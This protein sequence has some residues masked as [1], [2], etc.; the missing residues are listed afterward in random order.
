MI[1]APMTSRSDRIMRDIAR[2]QRDACVS[3][4]SGSC[5][6]LVLF[7]TFFFSEQGLEFVLYGAEEIGA[8]LPPS[9]QIIA[10]LWPFFASIAGGGILYACL[11]ASYWIAV[12]LRGIDRLLVTR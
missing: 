9:L 7:A 4:I 10:A 11:R 5:I 12:L 8:V 1:M 3:I 6:F 2:E